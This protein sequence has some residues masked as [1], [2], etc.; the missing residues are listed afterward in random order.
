MY[1][2]SDI[3]YEKGPFWVLKLKAKG[4]EVYRTGITYSTRCA[5]IGFTGD[6]GLKR[7]IAEIDRRMAKEAQT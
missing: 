5:Q 4:F 3:A 6:E 7:A 2:E 1:K